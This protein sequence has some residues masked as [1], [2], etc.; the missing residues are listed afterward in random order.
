MH[1]IEMIYYFAL[2]FEI[3]NDGDDFNG[4]WYAGCIRIGI[5]RAD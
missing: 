4:Q 5:K 2:S 3:Y 1:V